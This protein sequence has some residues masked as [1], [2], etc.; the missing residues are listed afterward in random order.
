MCGNNNTRMT[1]N[2]VALEMKVI[3]C[4]SVVDLSHN[5]WLIFG[6]DST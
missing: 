3:N 6:T 5:E 2:R 4:Y 1:A